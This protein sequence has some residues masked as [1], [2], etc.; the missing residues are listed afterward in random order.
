MSDRDVERYVEDLLAGRRP[1]PWQ[2]TDEEAERLRTAITMRAGRP[3]GDVPTEEFRTDLRRRLAAE[4]GEPGAEDSPATEGDNPIRRRWLL[5]ASAAAVTAAAAGVGVG[6]GA[7][8][9]HAASGGGQSTPQADPV[10]VPTEGEWHT[11][12]ASADLADGGTISFDTG[13]MRGFVCRRGDLVYALSGICTHQGCALWF[14]A[15]V[16]RCPCHRTSFDTAGQVVTHQLPRSPAPLPRIR[17]RENNGAIEI[18]AP[19]R[20]A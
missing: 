16:L 19:N 20:P 12:A 2:P 10:I 6:V 4:L 13:S 8:A 11:V 3:G 15:P 14:D 7:V 9:E 17:V 1:R 18:F 5:G